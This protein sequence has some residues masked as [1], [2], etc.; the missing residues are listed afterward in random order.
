[1]ILH[2]NKG[3]VKIATNKKD[4]SN[5]IR[6]LFFDIVLIFEVMNVFCFVDT[7]VLQ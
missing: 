7:K 1:M 3:K 2:T 6:K 5:K 4:G